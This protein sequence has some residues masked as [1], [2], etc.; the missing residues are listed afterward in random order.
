[1]LHVS[2]Q[3]TDIEAKL[4]R[5]DFNFLLSCESKLLSVKT[6]MLGQ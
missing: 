1:M 6:N 4:K 2:D 3:V 5:R